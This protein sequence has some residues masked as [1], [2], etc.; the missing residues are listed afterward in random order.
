MGAVRVSELLDN[1]PY[2]MSLGT[3]VLSVVDTDIKKLISKIVD[4][5]LDPDGAQ[6]AQD[7][8][9]GQAYSGRL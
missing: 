7:S 6:A 2:N 1:A 4:T 5:A 8:G 3:L 9:G